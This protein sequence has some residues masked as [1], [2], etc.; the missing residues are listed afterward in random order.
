[1]IGCRTNVMLP[2]LLILMYLVYSIRG[3]CAQDTI[4]SFEEKLKKD[5]NH[6]FQYAK[7]ISQEFPKCFFQKTK[8]NMKDTNKCRKNCEAYYAKCRN[9]VPESM[10]ALN[11]P[12]KLGLG[13]CMYDCQPSTKPVSQACLQQ[14]QSDFRLCFFGKVKAFKE[15]MVCVQSR[16]ICRTQPNCYRL[17]SIDPMT[18]GHRFRL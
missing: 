11:F 2:F 15:S 16:T 7:L 13:Q 1:M 4:D 18:L 12:C 17:D 9:A 3:N 10:V 8:Y 6:V 5:R 14:C